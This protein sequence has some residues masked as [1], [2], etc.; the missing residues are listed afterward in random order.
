MILPL[1]CTCFAFLFSSINQYVK[2]SIIWASTGHLSDHRQYSQHD[3]S[4]AFIIHTYTHCLFIIHTYTHCLF[5]IHT[6]THCLF[7]IHTYTHCL[8][9]IH[10]YTHCLVSFLMHVYAFISH[11]YTHCLVSFLMHVYAFIIHTYTHCLVSFLM[12]VY[13]KRCAC[14]LTLQKIPL[15]N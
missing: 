13:A 15:N 7:I 8:F 14:A 11:T 10:T 6:Y 3:A 9:I 2:Y 12:H 5:I 1:I 4:F